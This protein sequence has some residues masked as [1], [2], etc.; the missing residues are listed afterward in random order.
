VLCQ[1]IRFNIEQLRGMVHGLVEE[2]RRDLIEL[3]MLKMNAKGE[4][5][6]GQL[7]LID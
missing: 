6:E 5:E 2:T 1:D 3:M 7:P 4:V